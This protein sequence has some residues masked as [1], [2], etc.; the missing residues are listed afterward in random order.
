MPNWCNNFITFWSDGTPEGRK[1]LEDLHAK[2]EK[3]EEI[4]KQVNPEGLRV[5]IWEVYL[6]KYGYGITIDCYQ[7]GYI[8]WVG[9]LTEHDCFSIETEDA[10]SP[11]IEF[12]NA[13]LNYFYKG[14][15]TFTF[16]ASEPGMH[17]YQTN[18][19][20]VLPRYSPYIH[21]EGIDNCL[22][23][24]KLWDWSNPAFP[25]VKSHM[26]EMF[27]GGWYPDFSSYNKETNSYD[28][29]IY[30]TPYTSIDWDFEGD[31]DE[32]MAELEDMVTIKP[33]E[34]LEDLAGRLNG[35]L[36]LNPWE[37]VEIEDLIDDEIL[38]DAA[39]AAITKD[40]PI[41]EYGLVKPILDN[42]TTEVDK[43]E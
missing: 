15:L 38:T 36:Y 34:S 41:K 20:G 28:K 17:I 10:W 18:D 2:I 40:E 1:S 16:Q 22:L 23:Y 27:E 9:D 14:H 11:N 25:M 37:L 8:Y 42:F 33:N 21:T 5:G 6:A 3:T 35:T 30:R 26:I 31:E 12:W 4:M 24:D 29:Q 43:N 19:P 7:R 13:L 39:M 32:V